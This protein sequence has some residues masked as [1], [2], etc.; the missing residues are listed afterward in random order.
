MLMGGETAFGWGFV[1]V[2]GAGL[3]LPG[4]G[5]LFW[6]WYLVSAVASAVAH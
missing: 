4:Y 2:L 6:G 1:L 5:C 3:V